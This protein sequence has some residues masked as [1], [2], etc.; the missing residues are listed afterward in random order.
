MYRREQKTIGTRRELLERRDRVRTRVRALGREQF[1]RDIGRANDPVLWRPFVE[2]P[3]DPSGAQR[4]TEMIVQLAAGLSLNSIAEGV[5]TLEQLLLLGSYGCTRMQGYL[6]G[7]PVPAPIFEQWLDNPP[8][9]W[10][11]G[12]KKGQAKIGKGSAR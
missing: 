3:L 12:E 11:Q 1:A 10:I 5:E 6:F 8:F 2:A 7:K 9:R 4:P